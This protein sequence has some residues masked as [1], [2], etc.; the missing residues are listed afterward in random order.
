MGPSLDAFGLGNLVVAVVNTCSGAVA[1]PST[2][3]PAQ[4][5]QLAQP[6]DIT[7]QCATV[8]MSI[9]K[10]LS[11]LCCD[12]PMCASMPKTVSASRDQIISIGFL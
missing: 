9:T 11:E 8:V 6:T 7:L 10:Q 12:D 5:A 3:R 2:N 1:T 4:P